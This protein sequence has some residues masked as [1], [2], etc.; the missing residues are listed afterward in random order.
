M[1]M[2]TVFQQIN[3]HNSSRL[4]YMLEQHRPRLD[5]KICLL[6]YVV[7]VHVGMVASDLPYLYMIVSRLEYKSTPPNLISEK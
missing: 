6:Y 3:E 5:E 2:A 7:Q 4:D 1:P